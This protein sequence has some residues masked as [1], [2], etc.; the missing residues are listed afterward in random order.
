MPQMTLEMELADLL[1][2]KQ[3]WI[4]QIFSHLTAICMASSINKTPLLGKN[5]LSPILCV[6]LSYPNQ[7]PILFSS[8]T[9]LLPLLGSACFHLTPDKWLI[10]TSCFCSPPPSSEMGQSL[11]V[12]RVHAKPLILILPCLCL[13]TMCVVHHGSWKHAYEFI[14]VFMMVRK[15]CLNCLLCNEFRADYT[16][17]KWL[18]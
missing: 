16:E 8:L 1:I 4:S 18:R 13:W 2:P 3:N 11:Q 15:A 10:V 14:S 7:Y 17:C 6:L 5:A 9:S 12:R